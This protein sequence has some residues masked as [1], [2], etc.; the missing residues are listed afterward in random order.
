MSS[1][2]ELRSKLSQAPSRLLLG[3]AIMLVS[4]FLANNLISTND[5]TAVKVFI[6]STNLAAGQKLE[7][8][9]LTE[10]TL[11]KSVD[12]N[13]W[14]SDADLKPNMYLKTSLRE[15]DV[16]RKSDIE[17]ES[18]NRTSVSLLVQRGRI[19]ANV[20]VGD[21]VDIWDIVQPTLPVVEQAHIAGIEVLSGEIAL[22][23][24]VPSDSVREL[25][26]YQELA[27]TVPT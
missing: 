11:S 24:L 2:V 6:V 18:S 23:V 25:L 1:L 16:V 7:V 8:S 27:I 12:S 3:I 5:S 15:G 19:P 9:A 26:E 13:Q 22:T 20:K 10:V 17:Y 14:L 21:A 4:A